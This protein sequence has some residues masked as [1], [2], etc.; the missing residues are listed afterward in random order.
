MAQEIDQ[1]PRGP[2]ENEIGEALYQTRMLRIAELARRANIERPYLSQIVNGWR[3]PS[4][5]QLDAI[6]EALG[7]TREQLY[8]REEFRVAIEATRRTQEPA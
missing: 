3:L 5:E 4:A 6:S 7:W 2:Y 1:E 8:P